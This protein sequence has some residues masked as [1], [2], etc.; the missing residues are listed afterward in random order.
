MIDQR[1][2]QG[3]EAWKQLRRNCVTAT[4]ISKIIGINPW[5][6][7]LKL[8]SQKLGL[9]PEQKEN[10]AMRLG[11]QLE[12]VSLQMFIDKI[13]INFVPLVRFHPN[14]H[15]KMASLDGLSHC[16]K[17]AVEIKCSRAIFESA[18]DGYVAPMYKSQMQWQMYILDIRKMYFSAYWDREIII[19]EFERD[20][21]FLNEI[22]PKIHEFYKCMMDFQ[23]P[24]ATN[25]D[26]VKR[27]D[28]SW[29]IL[30]ESWRHKKAEL[31]RV[32]KEEEALRDELINLSGGQST[33]GG[34]ITLTKCHRRGLVDFSS[35]EILKSINLDEY[36]KKPT[37][38][39]RISENE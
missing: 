10:E 5:C 30:S 7:P 3:S 18:R 20:D 4:D 12:P 24:P 16:G 39:F 21:D 29:D 14:E 11:S 32:K 9:E 33:Q 26:Y 25:K 37:E 6:T 1:L 36:R 28:K 31:D 38:Y 8:W 23:S 2:V 27:D 15:W 13:G 34:G 22:M 17:H 19:I 35:I